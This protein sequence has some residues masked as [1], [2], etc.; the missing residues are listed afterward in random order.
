[1]GVRVSGWYFPTAM[2]C[3]LRAR[4]RWRDSQ[5]RIET[6]EIYGGLQQSGERWERALQSSRQGRQ[7]R[8]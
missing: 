1:M 4:I 6:K 2:L 3:I 8:S 7:L 5:L